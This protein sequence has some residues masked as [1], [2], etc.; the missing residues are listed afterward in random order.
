MFD[1]DDNRDRAQFFEAARQSAQREY[2]Q[3][4]T[5]AQALVRWGGALLELAHYKQGSESKEMIQQA[6]VQLNKAIKIDPKRPE[7]HWCLGNAYTSLGFLQDE[8]EKAKEHFNEAA[9]C[10]KSCQELEPG[11][12]TYKKAIDM[13]N[14]APDYYDEI[15]THIKAEQLA[16]GAGGLGEGRIWVWLQL[17]SETM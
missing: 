5:N 9:T 6:I 12:A 10:F 17:V 13:C 11:N 14:K 4:N 1:D 16:G 8:K 7:A 2:E 3:D 15:Q